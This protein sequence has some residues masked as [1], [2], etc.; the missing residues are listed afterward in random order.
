[1][2]RARFYIDKNEC[3]G[4]YRPE[5][6][7]IKYPYWCTGENLTAFILIAYVDSTKELKELWPEAR[8][9]D[10]ESCDNITFTS[11]FPKPEWYNPKTEKDG[12]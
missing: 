7:P 3:G 9:I 6:W 11:R 2:L 1:M 10:S 4:D 12:K 5:K 8:E